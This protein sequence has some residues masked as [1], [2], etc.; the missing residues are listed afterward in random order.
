MNRMNAAS[1]INVH[2]LQEEARKSEDKEAFTVLAKV[3][4]CRIGVGVRLKLLAEPTFFVEVLV[5]LCTSQ[6][7]VDLNL[8]DRGLSLLRRLEQNEYV[9]NCEEDGCISCELTVQLKDLSAEFKDTRTTI[10]R[11]MK[12]S[13]RHIDE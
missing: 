2:S 1:K 4:N 11:L 9:L 5:S 7:A 13:N 8:I 10:E 12:T 6:D 3:G